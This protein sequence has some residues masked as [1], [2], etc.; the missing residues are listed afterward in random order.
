MAVL[1]IGAQGALGRLCVDALRASGFEV[2]RAGR[3][4][5]TASDFRY[6]DLDQ[7]DSVSQ[8][9]AEAQLIV[10]TVRHPAHS[11][12]RTVI[13]EGGTLLNV[14]SLGAGDRAELQSDAAAAEG[15][16]VL[17]AGMA[18]GVYSLAL[19]EM[20]AAHPQADAVEI[21]GAW[22]LFQSSGPGAAIDFFGPA[23]RGRGRRPTRVIQFPEPIG[24]RRCLHLGGAEI[25]FFGE[26][27]EG[28]SAR[29]YLCFIERPVHAQ[30][31]ALNA[32]GLLSRLPSR[33]FTLGRRWTQRRTTSEPKR[34]VLA[35][36]RG[37]H[38]L[39]ACSVNGVG[40]YRMTAAAT[41]AFAEALLARRAK[42]PTLRG[43][44]GAEEFFE[45]TELRPGFEQRG[46]R[47]VPLP[48]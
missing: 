47:I 36:L 43:V 40:D 8:A 3:R 44:L 9:C 11:A 20:L 32:F 42:E 15:L 10:S 19:K 41:A 18:P 7:P 22:S 48:T 33:F 5:E 4:R 14:A 46:I 45:L 37:G 26:V 39:A 31:L 13:R 27:A 16:V 28:R 21:A 6:V 25:G 35:A 23:V 30:L 12:E 17:H 2:V 34:D 24:R 38:R 1:V 29:V